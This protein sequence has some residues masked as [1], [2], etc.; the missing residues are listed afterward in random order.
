MWFQR[1][2]ND[3][4][5]PVR[6]REFTIR[7]RRLLPD[8]THAYAVAP[9]SAAIDLFEKNPGCALTFLRVLTPVSG[10]S[11]A[12]SAAA[13]GFFQASACAPACRRQCASQASCRPFLFHAPSMAASKRLELE[14]ALWQLKSPHEIADISLEPANSADTLPVA[15][16][17]GEAQS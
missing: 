7:K 14:L 8:G 5:S 1:G 10:I 13:L 15:G 2:V 16:K 17:P 9:L 3:D 6:A 4:K 11:T 12:V